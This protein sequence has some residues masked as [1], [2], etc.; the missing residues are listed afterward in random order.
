[1]KYWPVIWAGI[2]R[3]PSEAVLTCLAITAAFT[4]FGLMLGLN[5]AYRRVVDSSRNDRLEVDPRFPLTTGLRLPL[6]MRGQ[7]ERLGG[8]TAVGGYYLLRGYYQ[9]P[10]NSERIFAVD[11]NMQRAWS[12]LPISSAQ[13]V[14]L[15]STPDGVLVS[16]RAALKWNLKPG[17]VFPL[18]TDPS[19]RAD[20]APYWVFRVL[21]IVP[22]D[23]ARIVGGRILGNFKYVDESLPLQ[24]RAI[25]MGFRVAIADAARA[26]ETSL[27]IDRLFA[28]SGNPTITI[29]DKTNEENALRSGTTPA[30]VALPIAG[31]GL[32][33]ILLLIANG[34]A[35]SV[36]VRIPEFAVLHTVGF[37]VRSLS[38]LVF[39]EAVIPCLIGALLG[40]ALA[41]YLTQWPWAYLPPDLT[42]GIPKPTLSSAVLAWA[43]LSASLLALLS[44]AAPILR[45]R[46]VS[47]TDALAGR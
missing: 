34:I 3:K 28:N 45:L 43:L 30:P 33:M 5:A 23:P 9:N 46:R 6:A 36:R 16:R 47:V 40:T 25:F 4:L 44:S 41:A 32:F 29:P 14:L 12:E 37:R 26:D 39:A 10:H 31:A 35:Q 19:V 17:D 11:E 21:A 24:D 15:R 2:W 7:I 42:R 13:W 20:G 22:D 8:V 38:T 27:T 1:V 18:I